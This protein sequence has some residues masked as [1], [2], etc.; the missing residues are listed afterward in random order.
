MGSGGLAG[1][2]GQQGWRWS[3][4]DEEEARGG[5]ERYINQGIK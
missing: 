1:R 4:G 5:G 3:R 2:G